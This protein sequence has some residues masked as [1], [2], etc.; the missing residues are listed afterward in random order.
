MFE[1][2][3]LGWG[4]RMLVSF[5]YIVGLS[6]LRCVV[7]VA[8]FILIGKIMREDQGFVCLVRNEMG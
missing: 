2:I 3:K 1:Q 8:N 7:L 4:L 5:T 6:F